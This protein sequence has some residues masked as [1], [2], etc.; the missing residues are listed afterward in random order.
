MEG[1]KVQLMGADWFPLGLNRIRACKYYI[2]GLKVCSLPFSEVPTIYSVLCARD[3]CDL[4]LLG[5][6]TSELFLLVSP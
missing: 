4:L 2:G 5:S 6:W 3:C 1:S